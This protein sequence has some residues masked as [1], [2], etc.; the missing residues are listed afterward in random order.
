M[1]A[2][3]LAIGVAACFALPS[4]VSAAEFEIGPG[5]VHVYHH[6]HYGYDQDCRSLREACMRKDE[7]GEQGQGNCRRYREV[8]R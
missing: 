6:R 7:L 2:Y 8:C 5:G 1:R 4:T 3:L